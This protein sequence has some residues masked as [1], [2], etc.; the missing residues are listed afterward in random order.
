MTPRRVAFVLVFVA[1]VIGL[2]YVALA[3]AYPGPS[4]RQVAARDAG[5]RLVENISGLSDGAAVD[6]AD[7]LDQPWERAV[8]M[9]AYMSGD[10][11]NKRLGFDW[12]SADDISGSD[13]SQRTMAFVQGTSVV[14][15]VHL[16]P[17]TFRLDETITSFNRADSTFVAARDPSG[18]VVLHRP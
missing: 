6:L 17:E 7:T 13:E 10:E 12:Y 15:E 4:P 3:L 9:E 2:F 8:L 11:M 18:L 16:R 1:G 14:A 5:D